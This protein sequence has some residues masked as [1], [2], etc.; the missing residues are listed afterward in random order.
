[1]LIRGAVVDVGVDGRVVTVVLMGEG[2]HMRDDAR[3]Y[4]PFGGTGE[5]GI[6][7]MMVIAV[8]ICERISASS[9]PGINPYSVS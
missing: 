2:R 4:W 9:S 3:S 6:G 7:Q 8:P 1:M 5:L